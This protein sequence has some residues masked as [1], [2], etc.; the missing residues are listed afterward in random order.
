LTLLL[1]SVIFYVFFDNSDR[2]EWF[3]V[4]VLFYYATGL[5]VLY[6]ALLTIIGLTIKRIKNNETGKTILKTTGISFFLL[7]VTL[8]VNFIKSNKDFNNWRQ[9][10]NQAEKTNKELE[11][12]FHQKQLDSLDNEISTSPDNYLALIQRGLLKR[13]NGQVEESI[14]DYELALKIK[15]DDF[16]ANLEMGYSLGLLDKK[17]EA[18]T[19]FRIAANI[20]TNSYF[21]RTNKQYIDNEKKNSR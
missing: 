6:L 19:Y 16:N 3:S 8:T 13:K 15:P 11:I 10:T 12:V 2:H 17:E 20:D 18:E 4:S 7:L 5:T 1:C 21:A 14:T 9:E